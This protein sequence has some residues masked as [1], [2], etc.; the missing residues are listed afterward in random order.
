MT[1]M[2]GC[3]IVESYSK[4]SSNK[5]ALPLLESPEAH[6]WEES[7]PCILRSHALSMDNSSAQHYL[8]CSPLLGIWGV[9]SQGSVRLLLRAYT[10]LNQDPVQHCSSPYCISVQNNQHSMHAFVILYHQMSTIGYR[11]PLYSWQSFKFLN[12]WPRY[13]SVQRN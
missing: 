8:V 3:N 2:V 9:R 10:Y 12:H 6:C 13:Y 1:H 4:I 11:S 7:R 5:T